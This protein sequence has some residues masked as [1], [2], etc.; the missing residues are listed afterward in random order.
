M[1][2]T[3]LIKMKRSAIL[4]GVIAGLL[5]AGAV[6]Y[7]YS[8]ALGNA[9]R[10]EVSPIE[11]DFGTIPY[12]SAEHTFNVKNIGG[13]ALEIFRV[14]TSCGCTKG[15][16]KSKRIAPGESTALVVTFDPNLMAEQIS[17]K[18][19]RK[20]YLKSNDPENPEVEIT[21]TANVSELA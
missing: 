20:I 15:E 16:V 19:L 12:E 13:E 10:I 14:S 18:I 5:I 8:A 1:R 9:P 4:T 7:A 17:G 6:L 2:F 3:R 21:I 11:Y